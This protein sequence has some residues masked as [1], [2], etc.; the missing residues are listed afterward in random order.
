FGSGSYDVV[1]VLGMEG[2][3]EVQ[4]V[5]RGVMIGSG[6]EPIIGLTVQGSGRMTWQHLIGG[7]RNE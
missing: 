1:G 2:E 3:Y 5:V 6:S 7:S 4:T